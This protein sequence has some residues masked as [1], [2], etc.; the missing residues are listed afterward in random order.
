MYSLI[1]E[2]STAVIDVANATGSLT[3]D[4]QQVWTP[5]KGEEVEF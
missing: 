4:T 3:N 1:P 5:S 2:N